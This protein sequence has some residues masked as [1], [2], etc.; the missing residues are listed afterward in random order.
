M[1]ALPR[2][3]MR[4]NTLMEMDT[5]SQL[6]VAQM[7]SKVKGKK[8]PKEPKEIKPPALEGGEPTGTV[9]SLNE[10]QKKS[11]PMVE[12]G[13]REALLQLSGT[14]MNGKAP[15]MEGEIPKNLLTKADAAEKIV[16]ELQ[17]AG[18]SWS[19]RYSNSWEIEANG[20][21]SRGNGNKG[22]PRRIKS[23]RF[24]E[25]E[26]K[27]LAKIGRDIPVNI[28]NFSPDKGYAQ[29]ELIGRFRRG[30]VKRTGKIIGDAPY[31]RTGRE[32]LEQVGAG[33]GGETLRYEIGGGDPK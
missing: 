30:K 32:K 21:I 7:P 11:L 12:Q 19:G 17:D 29:D 15:D 8:A 1:V 4:D 25:S 33:R 18:P 6:S 28:R 24:S 10:K 13:M 20:N 26:M 9:K 27:K 16:E 3:T 2:Y 14:I 22:N 31:S 23:P 5:S